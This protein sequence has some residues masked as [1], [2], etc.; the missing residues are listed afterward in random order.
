[1]LSQDK[2]NKYVKLTVSD[3]AKEAF[4]IDQDF[5]KQRLLDRLKFNNENGID[6]NNN[7]LSASEMQL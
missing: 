6:S 3:Q 5:Y 1:M 2:D 7:N 4:G